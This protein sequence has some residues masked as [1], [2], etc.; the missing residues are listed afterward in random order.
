[1]AR[2]T[3]WPGRWAVQRVGVGW[4]PTGGSKAGTGP[5]RR[6]GHV[7]AFGRVRERCGF[8]SRLG[9]SSDC[10]GFEVRVGR[11]RRDACMACVACAVPCAT[12]A[13]AWAQGHHRLGDTPP[14]YRD[15]HGADQRQCSSVHEPAGHRPSSSTGTSSTAHFQSHNWRG[16][17][18]Q[19]RRRKLLGGCAEE[20]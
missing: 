5:D 3:P 4:A 14:L 9:S 15:L 6:H 7:C 16:A 19:A 10:L 18:G 8:P 17:S 1:M 12:S 2:G 13:A 20:A 11:Q